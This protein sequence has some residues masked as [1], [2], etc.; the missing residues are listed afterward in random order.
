MSN[1]N[2]IDEMFVEFYDDF[3]D[4]LHEMIFVYMTECSRG[5]NNSTLHERIEEIN[6]A[7]IGDTMQRI[8]DDESDI[9]QYDDFF[10]Q[11]SEMCG[12]VIGQMVTRFA[13][14]F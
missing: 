12:K 8:C 3:K 4:H 13:E 6:Q 7:M 9:I 10:M 2:I 11:N 1:K 14:E 5:R